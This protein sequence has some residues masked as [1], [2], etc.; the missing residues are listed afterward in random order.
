[1]GGHNAIMEIFSSVLVKDLK[2]ELLLIQS[3]FWCSRYYGA[4]RIILRLIFLFLYV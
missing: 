4:V 1:M 2:K 3:R